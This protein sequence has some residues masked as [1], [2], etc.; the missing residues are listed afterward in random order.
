MAKSSGN[1][2]P[3]RGSEETRKNSR[4]EISERQF[5]R[6]SRDVVPDV[7]VEIP[8]NL[9]PTFTQQTETA[10]AEAPSPRS[11]IDEAKKGDKN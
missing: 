9:L 4:E 1:D 7:P 3:R 11:E 10:K 6:K 5:L 2:K 8:E